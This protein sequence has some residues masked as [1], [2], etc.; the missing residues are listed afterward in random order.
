M[1]TLGRRLRRHPENEK[2]IRKAFA[3]SRKKFREVRNKARAIHRSRCQAMKGHKAP[4]A[5]TPKKEK[6]G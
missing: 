1:T 4:K 5:S 6:K 2:F 3:V